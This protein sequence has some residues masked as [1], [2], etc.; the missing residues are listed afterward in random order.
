ML[1][2]LSMVSGY[3]TH[4]VT[5]VLDTVYYFRLRNPQRDSCFGHI[6]LFEAKKTIA[7]QIMDVSPPLR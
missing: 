2:D 1:S 4:S 7:P 3:E 5:E 6:V